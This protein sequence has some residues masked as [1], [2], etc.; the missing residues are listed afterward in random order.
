VLGKAIPPPP[1]P[2]IGA[3]LNEYWGELVKEIVEFF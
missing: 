1:P 3:V 2:R